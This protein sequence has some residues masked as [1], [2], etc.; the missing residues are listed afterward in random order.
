MTREGALLV[1]IGFTLVLIGLG[2]WAWRR[3]VRRDSG[4]VVPWGEVP[5]AARTIRDV[6]VFYVATTAYGQPL[7]RLAIAG[8][9][10]RSR[11]HLTITDAGL[12]LAL[13]GQPTIWLAAERILECAQATVAIDRVVEPGGLVRLAWDAAGTT[14]ETYLRPQDVP[15]RTLVGEIVALLPS[16]THSTGTNA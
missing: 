9:G 14:V 1:T 12:A 10:F 13:T 7:E 8:L 4:V 15:A 11:A 16:A 6:P 3:R 2:V 5:S